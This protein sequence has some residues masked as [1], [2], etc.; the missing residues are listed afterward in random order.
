MTKLES[1]DLNGGLDAAIY[2]FLLI[3]TFVSV[4]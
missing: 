4:T 2:S 1:Q 3:F